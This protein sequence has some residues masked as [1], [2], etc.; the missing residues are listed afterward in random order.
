[1]TKNKLYAFLNSTINR[2]MQAFPSALCSCGYANGYV[3]VSPEHSM[4]GK[5]YND[6]DVDV[7]CGLTFGAD[8]RTVKEWKDIE[9]LG[10]DSIDEVPDDY[11]VFGFDTMHCYDNLQ[12]CN[13]EWCIEE[14]LRLKKQLAK[15]EENV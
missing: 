11:W 14:T 13:K 3:A 2:E 7:H 9:C 1:M 8:A 6:V 12:T 4:H 5:N 10:F 15:M